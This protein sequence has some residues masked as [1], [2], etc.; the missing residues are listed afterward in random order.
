MRMGVDAKG[1]DYG[2]ARRWQQVPACQPWLCR[3]L[4][5]SVC[6][7]RPE[8]AAMR[9]APLR[10]IFTED[11]GVMNSLFD[12]VPAQ[13]FVWSVAA[14]VRAVADALDA[15]F[16]PVVVRGEVS[17]LH[18]AP[19]GHLYF[20]LKD[21][22]AQLQCVMYRSA[23][24]R[25][26]FAPREGA[27]VCA[28]GRLAVYALRGGLQLVAERL[29]LDGQG[30]LFEQFLRLK[31][32]LE[33]EG[34]FAPEHKRP[35]PTMPR[36]IGLVTS[37]SAAALHDF[38]TT[39]ARRAPQVRVLLAPAAVQG[40][41][42]LA[43][44]CAALQ[45]LYA[46]AGEIDAIALVRGGGALQDLHAFNDEQ[47]ARTIAA[48]PVPTV[49]GVG[50]ETDFTIADFAADVRAPTPTAAAE[51]IAPERAQL[52]AA[53]DA[54]A[55]RL[56]AAV[57]QRL[58]S[59]AQRLDW[60]AARLARPQE[61]VQRAALHLATLHARLRHASD[62]RLAAEAARLAQ[63]ATRLP[64]ALSAVP[65]REQV[66]LAQLAARLAALSPQ[67][68]LERGFAWLQTESGAPLTRAADAH[69][70]QHIA[71]ILGDGEVFARVTGQK[72]R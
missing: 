68:T 32:K 39:L 7:Q 12:A 62:A 51:L 34:L 17:G 70:G 2:A 67:R 69:A 23:T 22:S 58:N 9:P 1:V 29:K 45:R 21:S 33:A 72:L 64:R 46:L 24:A 30:A 37:L 47:L 63:L 6:I 15:R 52:F 42:A 16:T 66:R 3:S 53:L 4:W 35:L 19:S 8:R 59:E 40:S 38:C 25:L 13:P 54:A 44:L 48:S 50:H 11:D 28:R 65:E 20:A 60:F 36:A 61:A 49:S 10:R 43:E 27:L 18:R 41:T 5:E 55:R 57:H 31:A 26:A 71:A 14:L 56:S